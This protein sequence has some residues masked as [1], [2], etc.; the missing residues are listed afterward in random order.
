[1]DIARIGAPT[2]TAAHPGLVKET[3]RRLLEGRALWGTLDVS[4]ASRGIW[5]RVRLRVYPPGITHAQRRL[6]HLSHTWPVGGAIACLFALVFL[7]D[8]GPGLSTVTAL[9][10]YVAG[11]LVLGRLTRDLRAHS[12]TVTVA[13]EY[14]G[15]ELRE[16]G[17][18]HLL[19]AAA[20]RLMDLEV[21]RR[22][23]LVDPVRY[24]A[25]WAE[26]YDTLPAEAVRV[27]EHR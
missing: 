1:M 14:I 19:R 12:R 27:F 6:L 2:V 24:E 10:V 8:E 13:S 5:Q 3:V 25:E 17:N 7:S 11:F 16:F 20:T 15:G 21:R 18:V 22:T 4:P 26:V 23:G 9:S